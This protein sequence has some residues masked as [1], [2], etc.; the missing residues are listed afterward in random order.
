MSTAEVGMIARAQTDERMPGRP[1]LRQRLDGWKE[2]ALYLK[3]STRCVQRWERNE[4]LPVRR[5]GHSRGMS[6]YAFRDEL[7]TWWEN[8]G[9]GPL[10]I[11]SQSMPNQTAEH[12][13]S[14]AEPASESVRA[15]GAGHVAQ[16]RCALC[17]WRGLLYF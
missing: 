6:V 14:R 12:R 9:C 10:K 16:D 3:R 15:A 4:A 1:D 2:I 11:A 8:V 17:E 13:E 7:D 5:H